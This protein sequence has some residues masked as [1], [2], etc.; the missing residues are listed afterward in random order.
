MLALSLSI[1][2]SGESTGICLVNFV[3][4]WETS[5]SLL[6]KKILSW[7]TGLD[8]KCVQFYQNRFDWWL[9][10]S[11]KDIFPIDV[12]EERM[13]TNF[14]AITGTAS[15]TLLHLSLHQSANQIASV[16]C[17][18]GWKVEFPLEDSFNS[19]FAVL[20]AERRIACQHIVHQRSQTPPVDSFSVSLTSQNFWCPENERNVSE[21]MKPNK[22]SSLTCIQLFRRKS[23]QWFL[24]GYALC[25]T[26]NQFWKSTIDS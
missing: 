13:R 20:S 11:L 9:E 18:V 19:L 10:S 3:S 6:Y 26:Q 5:S 12:L 4:N 1:E 16:W 23:K 24:R 21:L 8:Y 17:Q 14:Q 25:I 2:S 22:R 15:Q 7:L